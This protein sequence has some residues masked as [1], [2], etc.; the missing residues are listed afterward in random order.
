MKNLNQNRVPFPNNLEGRANAILNVANSEIQAATLLILDDIPA[1]EKIMRERLARRVGEDILPEGPIFE[2]YLRQTILPAG[3]AEYTDSSIKGYRITEAGEKYKGILGFT[4]EYAHKKNRSMYSILGKTASPGKSRSPLNRVKIIEIIKGNPAIELTSIAEILNM[5]KTGIERHLKYLKKISFIDY[6]LCG[7]SKKNKSHRVF[8]WENIAD[9]STASKVDCC[10]DANTQLIARKLQEL[11]YCDPISLA[12]IINKDARLVRKVLSRLVDQGLARKEKWSNRVFSSFQ[13]TNNAQDFLEEYWNKIK[14]AL[15]DGPC[16]SRMPYD[17]PDEVLANTIELYLKVSP[18]KNA[19]PRVI[20]ESKIIRLLNDNPG[21]SA[22]EIG[23]ELSITPP[24]G[25]LSP[26]V[27]KRMLKI[28][29]IEGVS[30][31]YL[32]KGLN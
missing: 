8:L 29:K 32:N 7:E 27:E 5:K 14:D 10:G 9:S 18:A 26:M 30:R 11:T 31:Y 3:L 15:M 13:L 6:R 22:K 21:L 16:L 20:T 28:K 4:L 19:V 12:K 23:L 24:W 2:C 17:Q 25:N 1:N